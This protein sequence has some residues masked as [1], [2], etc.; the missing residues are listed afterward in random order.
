MLHDPMLRTKKEDIFCLCKDEF[1]HEFA[2]EEE[3]MTLEWKDHYNWRRQI[4]GHNLRVLDMKF[5]LKDVAKV[6]AQTM[7]TPFKEWAK[8]FRLKKRARKELKR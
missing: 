7:K 6:R 3:P 1:V 5:S 2:P 4:T 8:A